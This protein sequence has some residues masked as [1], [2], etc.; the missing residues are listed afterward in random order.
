MSSQTEVLKLEE[1][2]MNEL[3]LKVKDKTSYL[4]FNFTYYVIYVNYNKIELENKQIL[5]TC[6]LGMLKKSLTF[7]VCGLIQVAVL[8]KL[9][10]DM[11]M[12]YKKEVI[13]EVFALNFM[14]YYK[15][16]PNFIFLLFIFLSKIK[17]EK[18]INITFLKNLRQNYQEFFKNVDLAKLMLIFLHSDF[19]ERLA[20]E[21]I[22]TINELTQSFINLK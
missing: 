18:I 19:E 2:E 4:M 9:F 16:E 5:L 10:E 1:K 3:V 6:L 7:N 15:L 13:K 12:K 21:K 11:N 22:F 20:K 8:S 17:D 14:Q